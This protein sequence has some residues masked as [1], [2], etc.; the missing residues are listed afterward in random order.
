MTLMPHSKFRSRLAGIALSV[1]VFT[2]FCATDNLVI[3]V[4]AEGHTAIETR[5]GADQCCGG[6]VE[7]STTALSGEQRCS[8]GG[9]VDSALVTAASK[10]RPSFL[11]VAP[12]VLLVAFGGPPPS[13]SVIRVTPQPVLLSYEHPP[14]STVLLI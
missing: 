11:A 5:I 8:P 2:A 6:A 3:C 9:C 1:Q 7:T 14:R 10:D 4:G 13:R 12:A